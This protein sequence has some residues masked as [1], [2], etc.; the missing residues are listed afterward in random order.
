MERRRERYLIIYI[1]RILEG[2]V[3]NFRP[4]E[5]G[6]VRAIWHARRGRHCA[7]PAV[8]RQSPASVQRIRYSSFAILGP[9]LFNTIPMD[10]RN[11]TNCSV[12]TFKRSLDKYLR[13]V[14]DE[15]L[16]RGYTAM[17]RSES[18][19]LIHMAQFASSHRI[20][21]EEPRQKN[22]AGRKTLLRSKR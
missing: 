2:Q 1:W 19:S 10:V 21:L 20:Q 12:D 8:S 14:P 3:P 11:M 22:T 4:A 18:N 16:V 5:Q 15:P 9:R 17:R 13:T 6:G 7:V